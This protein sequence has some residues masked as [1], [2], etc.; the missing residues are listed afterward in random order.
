VNNGAA[1]MRESHFRSRAVPVALSLIL[2]VFW[3]VLAYRAFQ[4]GDMMM[5]GVFLAAGIALTI[6]RLRGAARRSS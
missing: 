4:R 5:A 2:L 1:K 6:W 3:L